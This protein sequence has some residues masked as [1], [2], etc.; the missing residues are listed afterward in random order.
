MVHSDVH[1]L[2]KKCD[3]YSNDCEVVREWRFNHAQVVHAG[4]ILTRFTVIWW[5]Q[6]YCDTRYNYLIFQWDLPDNRDIAY[7]SRAA[8]CLKHLF[9]LQSSHQQNPCAKSHIDFVRKIAAH[10]A[11]HIGHVIRQYS[12]LDSANESIHRF[13]TT[14][15]KHYNPRL[16]LMRWNWLRWGPLFTNDHV[17]FG[18]KTSEILP[19]TKCRWTINLE[20][21]IH[22]S[23]LY[24]WSYDW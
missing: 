5:C 2:L 7:S 15:R 6:T 20:R 9:L 16:G 22:L 24:A 14:E 3:Q 13:F 23:V 19:E 21:T 11:I 18:T 8:F 17:L 12:E 4:R 1:N 10:F